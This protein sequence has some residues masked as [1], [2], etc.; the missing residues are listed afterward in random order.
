MKHPDDIGNLY[1]RF[2]GDPA[3]YHEIA[4]EDEV[5]HARQRWPILLALS[6][7]AIDI[8]LAVTDG[9]P[10]S[11]QGSAAYIAGR[12]D[13]GRAADR[14]AAAPSTVRTGMKGLRRLFARAL[15]PSAAP[16][17]KPVDRVDAAPR[18]GALGAGQVTSAGI[19]DSA[20]SAVG[21]RAPIPT[22][23]VAT[24]TAAPHRLF[25]REQPVKEQND[26]RAL[27]ARISEAGRALPSE[28]GAGS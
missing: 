8:P 9:K 19:A 11:A 22:A 4:R 26:L 7:V 14:H 17:V 3:S 23:A 12:Q 2:G 10:R 20:A 21:R 18:F 6:E 28:P 15:R 1:R 24:D 16:V 27:F 5:A 13:G 25:P